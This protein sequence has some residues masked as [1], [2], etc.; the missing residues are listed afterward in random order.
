MLRVGATAAMVF[1]L[2][3]SAAAQQGT[4][5][6]ID[7]LA[8]RFEQAEGELRT[9]TS[10][11]REL[12]GR[13]K[14]YERLAAE[15]TDRMAERT[16]RVATRLRVMYRLRRRGLL[17]YLFSARSVH[18]L[19]ES[20]RYLL[21]I[22]RQDERA[23]RTWAEEREALEVATDRAE[24]DRE[25]MVR[26][27]GE[28]ALR[29][30]ELD[31]LRREH[32]VA[33]G[34]IPEEL[35]RGQQGI[36]LAG[37]ESAVA[38]ATE[39]Q[40]VPT[41]SPAEA[42]SPTSNDTPFG[43]RK[44]ALPLPAQGEILTAGRGIAVLAAAGSPIRAVARGRVQ[45]ILWIQGYGI[46]CIVDHGEGWFTVYGHAAGFTVV[47]GQ[48]VAA[49]TTLGTVGDTGSVEGPRLHFEVRKD[50]VAEPPLQWLSLPSGQLVRKP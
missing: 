15:R 17:P 23:I 32:T 37:S 8:R 24:A 27:A 43:R 36:R 42:A 20:S 35:R 33:V 29:R 3:S 4:F 28:A 39:R 38:E 11:L 13:I 14:E 30:Q 18:E 1:L 22:V 44:G 49:G 45:R 7:A 21:H 26:L 9:S 41:H 46:V 10:R 50:R 31:E 48:E 47:E 16:E 19:L 6:E 5:A 2:S 34:R 40:V 25:E 12:D